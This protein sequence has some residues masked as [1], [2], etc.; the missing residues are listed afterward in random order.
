MENTADGWKSFQ[1]SN[2]GIHFLTE[3][4]FELKMTMC[5]KMYKY[6]LYLQQVTM[7]DEVKKS[8]KKT[9]LIVG[10]QEVRFAL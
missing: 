5:T 3:E 2:C 1:H 8:T 7:Q 9:G 10:K 6:S 4:I